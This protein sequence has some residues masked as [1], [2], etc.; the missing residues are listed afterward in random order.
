MISIETYV[1]N[2]KYTD[3]QIKDI[4]EVAIEEAVAEA[5]EI[6]NAYT[7]QQV[8]IAAWKIEFVNVLPSEDIDLHTIYFVPIDMTE[9]SDNN[10]YYEYI[11]VNGRWEQ[12]GSTEFKPSDYMT[13]QETMDYIAAYVAGHAYVLPP[14]TSDTLG[15]VKVDTNTINLENDG[16]ISI[17]SIENNDITNL[18]H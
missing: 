6:A 8:A 12:I 1:L 11:Y 4:E 3:Q 2:K 16:K 10:Y 18:F 7:D 13:K 5:V 15:G 14:A 9:E 17:V